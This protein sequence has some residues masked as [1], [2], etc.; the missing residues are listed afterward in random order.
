MN[1]TEALIRRYYAAFNA[2][3]IDGMLACLADDIAHD[4]NEGRRET[5]KAAFGAFLE[6]MNYCYREQLTDIRIAVGEDGA[7]AAAEYLVHGEYLVTDDGLPPATGQK[8]LLPGGAF[9]DVKDGE[10]ARVT[11]YYNLADWLKQV[12]A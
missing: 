7:Y 10:I 3:D 12:Q 11:N 4:V 1:P 9:F 8:Y 5:G 6:R 2:A